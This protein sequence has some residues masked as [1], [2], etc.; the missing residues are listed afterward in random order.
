VD[1]ALAEIS[2]A[3][4]PLEAAVSPDG[5]RLAYVQSAAP[6]K[7]EIYSVSLAVG[8]SKAV[9]VSAGESTYDESSVEWSPDSK[10]IA[11]LSDREQAGQFQLYV[12]V[13]A[14]GRARQLT[15]LKGLLQDPRWSPDGKR[16]AILF[17]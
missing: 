2:A 10:Q 11:F 3:R 16:I 4:W 15:H 1:P 5:S 17:T 6:G 12:A 8:D 7:S 14:G 13:G 9:R